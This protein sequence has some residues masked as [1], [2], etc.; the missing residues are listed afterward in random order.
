MVNYDKIIL[1]LLS[2]IQTLEKQVADIKS[3]YV[4]CDDDE[5]DDGDGKG[6]ITRSQARAR[7]IETIQDKFPDYFADVASRKEGSGIKVLKP[8]VGERRPIIIKFYHSKSF[9]HRSGSYEHSWHVVRLEDVLS[10][11]VDLCLFSYVDSD[12]NWHY[13]IYDPNE[14]GMYR[15]ENRSEDEQIL[16]LYFVVKDGKALEVREESVDVTD[17][18]NNWSMLG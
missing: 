16:H 18:L 12:D 2:R 13:F 10:T 15:D 14:I 11:Y 1:E 3:E 8:D 9:K 6:D 4:L 7:A 5:S 17:H